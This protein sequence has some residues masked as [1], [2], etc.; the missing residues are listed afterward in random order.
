MEHLVWVALIPAAGFLVF[1]FALVRARMLAAEDRR[2]A[3]STGQAYFSHFGEAFVGRTHLKSPFAHLTAT[4]T[5]L[6]LAF[7]WK[8]Y[9]FPRISIRRLGLWNPLWGGLVIRHSN[10]VYPSDVVFVPRDIKALR[11][12][13]VSLGYQFADEYLSSD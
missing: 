5:M 8:R 2:W 1:I 3:A 10:P 4:P 9:E 6:R 7:G 11:T 12:E 13:L